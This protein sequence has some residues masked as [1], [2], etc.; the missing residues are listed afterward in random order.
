MVVMVVVVM[1]VVVVI[2]SSTSP[3]DKAVSLVSWIPGS[4]LFFTPGSSD[5]PFSALTEVVRTGGGRVA[6]MITS[7]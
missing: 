5:S 2:P 1:M 7:P 6:S 4:V 3:V